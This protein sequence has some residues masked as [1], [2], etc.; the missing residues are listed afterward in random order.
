MKKKRWMQSAVKKKGSFTA[1]CKRQGYKGVTR[2]CINKGKKS[3]NPTTRR[4][5]TLAQTFRKYRKK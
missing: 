5:A 2:A 1:Y 4:R 3:S